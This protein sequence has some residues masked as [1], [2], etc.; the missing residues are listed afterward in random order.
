MNFNDI[1]ICLTKQLSK[2][3]KKNEGIYFTPKNIITKIVDFVLHEKPNINTILEPSCGS[4]QFIEY[5]LEKGKDVYGIEK[6]ETIYN[7]VKEKYN[8][9]NVDFL[10]HTFTST[11]DLVIGNPPYF[12]IPKKEVDKKYISFFTGRPNIYILFIIKSFELLNEHGILAFVLPTNFLNCIY[13]N[14]L[15]KYLSEY[16]ILDIYTTSEKFLDTSQ[17]IC[18]IIIQKTKFISKFFIQ[19][20]NI[21][22]FKS[23]EALEKIKTLRE[24]TTTLY[25]LGCKMNI[26]TVVWNQCKK[27]LTDDPTKTLLIYSSDFKN[28][29]LYIQ[30]Y[31]DTSK[32]NYITKKG[33]SKKVLLVN[34]GYGTGK[35]KLNYCLIEHTNYIAEN[36][37][38]VINAEEHI[39]PR[40]IS[41]FENKK[42]KEFIDLV[43]SNNAINIEEFL[44]ILP[45]F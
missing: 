15:R 31:T 5:L 2:E 16:K 1:S 3:T 41:S 45:I 12:V 43:F 26:G 19:F 29:V 22:L 20:D 8:I 6:N 23:E 24:N 25:K 36:H 34:R 35:Y 40:I 21:V 13:Y 14:Q 27:D 7:A 4:G 38:I 11:F 44:H 42:T 28:N 18:V 37:C 33:S 10:K 32:K 17:D 30:K 39:Y 9:Q